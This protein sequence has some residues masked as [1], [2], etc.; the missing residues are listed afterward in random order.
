MAILATVDLVC[1]T[2]VVIGLLTKCRD[3]LLPWLIL[4]GAILVFS[5]ILFIKMATADS[6]NLFYTWTAFAMVIVTCL[7]LVGLEYD[8]MAPTE[9]GQLYQQNLQYTTLHM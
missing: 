9:R 1:N 2:L 6:I 8:S 7:T 4:N 5:A 3:A